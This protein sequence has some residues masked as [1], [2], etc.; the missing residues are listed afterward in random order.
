[1]AYF[2][3]FN[4]T[5]LKWKYKLNALAGAMIGVLGLTII[6]NITTINSTLQNK[7]DLIFLIVAEFITA[8]DRT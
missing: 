7:S 1:M 5:N 3:F 6:Y 8:Q 4:F 2:F